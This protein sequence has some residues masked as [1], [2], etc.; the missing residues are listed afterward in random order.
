VL[1][2]GSHDEWQ[3][4][5]GRP[6]GETPLLGRAALNVFL[7][8][9]HSRG[10]ELVASEVSGLL[11]AARVPADERDGV[12]AYIEDALHLL[13]VYDRSM[14]DDGGDDVGPEGDVPWGTLVI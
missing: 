12:V 9:V 7:V 4:L 3:A 2:Q 14:G 8:G 13:E 6:Q 5:M 1:S 10:E 11:D